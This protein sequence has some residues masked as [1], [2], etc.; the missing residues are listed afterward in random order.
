MFVFQLLVSHTS[1]N[2]ISEKKPIKSYRNCIFRF[3]VNS[4]MTLIAQGLLFRV[5]FGKDKLIS[6]NFLIHF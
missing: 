5:D 6:D 3:V 1:T 4:L 2:S